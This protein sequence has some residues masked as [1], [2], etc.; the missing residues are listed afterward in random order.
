MRARLVENAATPE[1]LIELN[2]QNRAVFGSPALSRVVDVRLPAARDAY[3]RSYRPDGVARQMRAAI[4]DGS[5][6]DRLR[7]LTCRRS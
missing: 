4:A 6:V 2:A 3:Q 5:R 1:A 7:A